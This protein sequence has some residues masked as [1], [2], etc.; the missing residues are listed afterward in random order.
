[1]RRLLTD[2]MLGRLTTYLRMCGYDTEY[3]LDLGLESDAEIRE[4]AM[5]EGRVLLTRD[6]EL[7]AR[8]EDA[9]L[10]S[11]RDVEAMLATLQEAGYELTLPET[12]RRCSTCNGSLT[13]VPPESRTPEY[14]PD[15]RSAA[16]WRCTACG[17]H[18]WKG[19]HWDSV[20]NTLP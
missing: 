3:T 13:R 17:Q 14:A 12:P 10:L 8:T 18:F 19:S 20:S 5:T 7:A 15:P 6:R 16:V 1:M 2:T 11:S 4:Y 9:V